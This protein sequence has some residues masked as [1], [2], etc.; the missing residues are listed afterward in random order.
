MDDQGY[1]K[2]LAIDSQYLSA[3]WIVEINVLVMLL[4]TDDSELKVEYTH[5]DDTSKTCT[6]G[7]FWSNDHDVAPYV[8]AEKF[9]AALI[10][11][12]CKYSSEQVLGHLYDFKHLSFQTKSY[13]V[14]L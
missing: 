3:I 1:T 5:Q 14:V 2:R 7:T 12:V 8:Q 4:R 6:L 11:H 10:Q 13:Q 9:D